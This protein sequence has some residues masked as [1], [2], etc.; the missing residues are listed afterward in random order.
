MKTTITLCL[1]SVLSLISSTNLSAQNSNAFFTTAT[2]ASL[3]TNTPFARVL[4]FTGNIS[5]DKVLLNWTVAENQ[6]ANQFEVEKSVNG[7]DFVL[8]AFVF[9]T[10]KKD[11]ENY[12]FYEKAKTTKTYYRVKIILK[13]GTIDYSPVIIFGDDK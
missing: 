5:N 13:N 10:D 9:G 4:N 7:T 8:A 1:I 12:M 11:A 6:Y 2:T 3:N